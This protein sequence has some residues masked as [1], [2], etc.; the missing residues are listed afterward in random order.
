MKKYLI[1]LVSFVLVA[2]ASNSTLDFRIRVI[3][4][5][6]VDP[7]VA[8]KIAL[9][10]AAKSYSPYGGLEVEVYPEDRSCER[11]SKDLR[12]EFCGADYSI[13]TFNTENK[14]TEWIRVDLSEDKNCSYKFT[15][16]N[17]GII[18]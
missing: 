15:R 7:V 3:P 14:S 2:C 8:R 9:A 12:S 1:F 11:L 18:E 17:F 6:N 4:I 5:G 16:T 13:F 10:W